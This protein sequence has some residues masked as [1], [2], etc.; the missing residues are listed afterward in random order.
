MRFHPLNKVKLNFYDEPKKAGNYQVFLENKVVDNISFNYPKNESNL[1]LKNGNNY[2]DFEEIN[3]LNS[4]FNDLKSN[5][6][7]TSYWKF[8]IILALI[9]MVA[10]V[11]IQ[12]FVK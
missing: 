6:S 4:F 11:L 2:K 1:L 10:E 3:S 9:C 8:F 12:K 5:R 7:N